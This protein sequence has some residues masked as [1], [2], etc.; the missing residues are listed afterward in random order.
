MAG[1]PMDRAAAYILEKIPV[2]R[3]NWELRKMRA[4]PLQI[5]LLANHERDTQKKAKC[6]KSFLRYKEKAFLFLLSY[7][8]YCTQF[9]TTKNK[10]K[11]N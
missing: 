2:L 6:M 8:C 9:I 4:K 10:C 5:E 1:N 11:K 7:K 3:L